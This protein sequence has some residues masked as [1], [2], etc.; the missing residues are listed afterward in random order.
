[1][2]HVKLRWGEP[3]AEPALGD[4]VAAAYLD[5]QARLRDESGLK[6]ASPRA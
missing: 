4:L 2:R 1:M 3:L 6:P 5:M